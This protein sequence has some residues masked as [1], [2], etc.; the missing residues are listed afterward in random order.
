MKACA[1]IALV[2]ACGARLAAADARITVPLCA[3]LTIVTAISQPEGDY[4]SIKSVESIDS[5]GVQLRYSSER[6]VQD[7]RGGPSHLEKLN[8][9]RL[10][11]LADLQTSTMYLQQYQTDLANSI[12]GTTA[13]GTSSAVLSELKNKGAARLAMFDLPPPLPGAR[14]LSSDPNAHPNAI[15]YAETYGIERADDSP[16]TI[17][18]VVNGVTTDLPAIHATGKS[19]YYGYKAEFFFLDDV[20]NPLALKW[21]LRIGSVLSGTRAGMDRDTLQVVKIAY[22][23]SAPAGQVGALEQALAE[24]RRALVFDIYFSFNS[25]ELRKES[26]PTLREIGDLLHRHGDWKLSIEGHTDNVAGDAFNLD[27]SKRR[28]AAVKDALVKNFAID[29]GRLTTTGHGRSQPAD[30][31]ETVEGRA[32]NRRVELVRWE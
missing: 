3:G 28:A 5:N 30:T 9:S 18:L 6:S 16:V 29:A 14:K 1:V 22:H 31:N 24:H 4:E 19:E 17:P 21:R 12:P 11:R 32:R 23:C 15:D 8:L 20:A 26:E 2:L 10:V 7:V 27:L 13:I 25:A